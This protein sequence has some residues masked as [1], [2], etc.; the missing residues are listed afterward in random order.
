MKRKPTKWEKIFANEPT[1]KS[2]FSKIYTEFMQLNIKKAKHPIEKWADD[3][4]KHF[5][6]ED[7]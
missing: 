5:S 6:K 3:L 2:L 4:N 1:D 7:I